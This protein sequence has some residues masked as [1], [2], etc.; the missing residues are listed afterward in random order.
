M[1]V[2][3]RAAESGMGHDQLHG[4][5]RTRS[6]PTASAE[7]KILSLSSRPSLNAS[8][9][10]KV[11]E[12]HLSSQEGDRFAIPIVI[13][14]QLSSKLREHIATVESE[15]ASMGRYESLEYCK[16]QSLE[17]PCSTE[18]LKTLVEFF[19]A[20]LQLDVKLSQEKA[21]M[22]IEQQQEYWRDYFY[23]RIAWKMDLDIF[24]DETLQ[25]AEFLSMTS[26]YDLLWCCFRVRAMSRFDYE[27]MEVYMD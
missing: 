17:I 3:P 8:S 19:T 11:R 9:G 15:C 21:Y 13:A 25:V 22:S 23:I 14:E 6:D 4:L 5:N 16:R 1:L 26:L 12:I 24:A 18:V 27:A 20:K 7:G 2:H 10:P